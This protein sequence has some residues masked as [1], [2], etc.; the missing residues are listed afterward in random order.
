MASR[1]GSASARNPTKDKESH[2][3][4]PSTANGSKTEQHVKFGHLPKPLRD[5]PA[6]NSK[7]SDTK[8]PKDTANNRARNAGSTPESTK[9][10]EK[11]K[12]EWRGYIAEEKV[13][14][15]QLSREALKDALA[16]NKDRR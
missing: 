3:N 9:E 12:T 1:Q 2:V 10:F 7:A 11:L 4:K 6:G 8:K 14:M 16:R 15:N 13:L 5:A